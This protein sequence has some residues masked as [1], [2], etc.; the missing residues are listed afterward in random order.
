MGNKVGSLRAT[1]RQIANIKRYDGQP[2]A[3]H[4]QMTRF[5]LVYKLA[6]S[7]RANSVRPMVDE[8]TRVLMESKR[9]LISTRY[10]SNCRLSSSACSCTHSYE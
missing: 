7:E 9:F 2:A 3:H 5:S 4:M 6:R 10:K 8:R 1:T